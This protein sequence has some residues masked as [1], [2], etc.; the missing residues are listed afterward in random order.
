MGEAGETDFCVEIRSIQVPCGMCITMI[1]SQELREN[2]AHWMKS[3]LGDFNKGIVYKMCEIEGNV[4]EACRVLRVASEWIKQ[5]GDT[6][7]EEDT[8]GEK[9]KR[10]KWETPVST[11]IKMLDFKTILIHINSYSVSH[12]YW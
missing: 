8:S 7:P 5:G 10:H 6:E 11:Y 3:N 1:N 2:E 9:R 12:F 4:Q